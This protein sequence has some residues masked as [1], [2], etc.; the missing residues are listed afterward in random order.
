MNCWNLGIRVPKQVWLL[1]KQSPHPPW[2]TLKNWEHFFFFFSWVFSLNHERPVINRIKIFFP[3]LNFTSKVVS[4]HLKNSLGWRDEVL[5]HF[6]VC[7]MCAFETPTSLE[8]AGCPPFC[9]RNAWTT[10]VP[11]I[12]YFSHIISVCKHV[13]KW[14]NKP[15]DDCNNKK[16]YIK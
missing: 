8:F 3:F 13:F 15:L 10:M 6:S 11:L 9:Q 16:I 14:L 2:T 1:G 7:L 4:M 12:K 5:G